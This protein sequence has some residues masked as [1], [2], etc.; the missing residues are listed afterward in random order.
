M[1]AHKAG[2]Q[3]ESRAPVFNRREIQGAAGSD[4]PEPSVADRRRHQG[5][6]V[7]VDPIEDH[8]VATLPD[9]PEEQKGGCEAEVAGWKRNGVKQLVQPSRRFSRADA[10][11]EGGNLCS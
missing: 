1:F 6:M 8:T 2:L 4:S 11:P 7:V 3:R 5:N 9:D 10:G